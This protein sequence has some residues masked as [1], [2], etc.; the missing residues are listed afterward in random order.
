MRF[1]LKS[2]RL[3]CLAHSA[4]STLVHL[5]ISATPP[6][7]SPPR[8]IYRL[9]HGATGSIHC[10][11]DTR[12]LTSR[13]GEEKTTSPM[14]LVTLFWYTTTSTS[15]FSPP[16]SDLPI[17]AASGRMRPTAHELRTRS[18]AQKHRRK[19]HKQKKRSE[20]VNATCR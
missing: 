8:K 20:K 4:D 6:P 18:D 10:G 9:G 15:C 13:F 2:I 1:L 16:P 19:S 3:C 11:H 14:T 7:M 5:W 12:A 17:T